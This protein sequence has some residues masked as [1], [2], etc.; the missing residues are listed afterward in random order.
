MVRA[1]LFAAALACLAAEPAARPDGDPPGHGTQRLGLEALKLAHARFSGDACIGAIDLTAF[2]RIEPG[3]PAQDQF[4][5]VFRSPS[6]NRMRYEARVCLPV[7]EGKPD[8]R[9]QG[10]WEATESKVTPPAS[11]LPARLVDSGEALLVAERN[12]LPK[13]PVD[14]LRLALRAVPKKGKGLARHEKLRGKSVWVIESREQCQVIDAAALKPLHKGSC[15][16]IGW[17]E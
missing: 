10:E 5:F 1:A 16:S 13:A 4:A 12:G 11:C 17:P 2:R 7:S 6:L 14:G 3:A 9:C 8:P 15:K